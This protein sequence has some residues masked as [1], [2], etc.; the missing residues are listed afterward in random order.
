MKLIKAN[1]MKYHA[2]SKTERKV[3][4]TEPAL[5]DTLTSGM[6]KEEQQKA[7]ERIKEVHRDKLQKKHQEYLDRVPYGDFV[8]MKTDNDG[9]ISVSLAKAKMLPESDER[10]KVVKSKISDVGQVVEIEYDVYVAEGSFE[11]NGTIF[12]YFDSNQEKGAVI[13]DDLDE[14]VTLNK[15][16]S[17]ASKVY[18]AFKST[19]KRMSAKIGNATFVGMIQE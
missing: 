14:G 17:K 4:K 2:S 10:V 3:P 7:E 12:Q 18:V 15:G 8:E 13:L 16:E 6:T 5:I 9:K 19:E 1:P 11:Y